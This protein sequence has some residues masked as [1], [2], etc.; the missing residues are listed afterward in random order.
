MA[1]NENTLPIVQE[2]KKQERVIEHRIVHVEKIVDI[3]GACCRNPLL[4]AITVM[5]IPAGDNVK[6]TGIR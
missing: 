5:F 6:N 2:R 3:K 4:S 1:N